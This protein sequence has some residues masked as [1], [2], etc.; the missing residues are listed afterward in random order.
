MIRDAVVSDLATICEIYN[1]YI[2]NT[3]VSFETDALSEQEMAARVFAPTLALPWMVIED[4]GKVV[5]YAYGSIWKARQA[6]DK[7]VET[8]VYIDYEHTGKRLGI[9]LYSE[10]LARVTRLGYH[11]AIGGICVPNDG[12]IGL[13]QR[14]GYE[15]VGHYKEIGK[16][17]GKWL[18]VQYYQ[19]FLDGRRN[20]NE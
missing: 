4:E 8:T 16:K 18:D 11:V 2:L 6:Y 13:H 19:I 3:S 7:T 10:L 9:T 15:K 14:L 5:G 20:I 12:S 1:Y 17:F